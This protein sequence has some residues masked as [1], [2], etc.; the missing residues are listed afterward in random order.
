MAGKRQGPLDDAEL[1]AGRILGTS[2]LDEPRAGMADI[3]GDEP[4]TPGRVDAAEAVTGHRP[5][6]GGEAPPGGIPGDDSALEGGSATLEGDDA[7]E[8]PPPAS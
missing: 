3:T 2:P 4:R 7:I 5:V 6:P 1:D 8:E